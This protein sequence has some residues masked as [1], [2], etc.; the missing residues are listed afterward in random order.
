[1]WRLGR[2]KSEVAAGVVILA[3]LVGA[4]ATLRR[5]GAR[6][7]GDVAHL[8]EVD[9]ITERVGTG[10]G[11]S[12][13]LWGNSL[14]GAGVDPAQ[15]RGMLSEALDDSV[16]VGAVRPDGSGPLE[17][18]YLFRRSVVRRDLRADLLVLGVGPGHLFDRPPS[19][20]L[21]RLAAH[22]LASGDIPE[23]FA[24]DVV[25]LESR[26]SFLFSR[27]SRARSLRDRI[28]DRV[29]TA[30]VPGYR[31]IAPV[32][33]APPAPPPGSP[34][35]TR[36]YGQLRRFL[37]EVS[38]AGIP[39]VAVVMPAPESWPLEPEV[40]REMA[41][42]GAVVLDV[43]ELASLPPARFP[44]G[45]HLDAAGRETFT[46]ALAPRLAALLQGPRR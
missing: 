24:S 33:L 32:L 6:L 19:Q 41:R 3:L 35:P 29:L 9:D 26:A 17:W 7:S 40:A 4:E 44:D 12:V 14:I 10:P 43:R 46:A 16:R 37:D 15:L 45:E 11:R 34:P 25:D 1:M 20:A 5:E 28:R 42:V 18:R 22:H 23:L 39:I 13:L 36:T 8:L 31:E 27:L 2:L 21:D 38:A 30:L